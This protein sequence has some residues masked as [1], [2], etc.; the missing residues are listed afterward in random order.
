MA[1][2]GRWTTGSTEVLLWS[3][4]NLTL[5]VPVVIAWMVGIS[6]VSRAFAGVLAGCDTLSP[7][8]ST[9]LSAY[10]VALCVV[11]LAEFTAHVGVLVKAIA[12]HYDA[13]IFEHVRPTFLSMAATALTAVRLV[14]TV[15]GTL[16][17]ALVVRHCGDAIGLRVLIAVVV[18]CGW[19]AIAV[20]GICAMVLFQH[21]TQSRT[22]EEWKALAR[23]MLCHACWTGDRQRDIEE[24]GFETIAANLAELAADIP[25]ANFSDMILSMAMVRALQKRQPRRVFLQ[26]PTA[27]PPCL[28]KSPPSST[29]SS[30]P[31][32]RPYSPLLGDASA[33][34]PDLGAGDWDRLQGACHFSKYALGAYGAPL[35]AMMRPWAACCLPNCLLQ[36]RT[37]LHAVGCCACSIRAFLLRTGLSRADVIY[38]NLTSQAGTAVFYVAADH[39]R[40][41]LVVCVRG[42]HSLQDLLNDLIIDVR[43]LAPYGFPPGSHMHG[44]VLN[45]AINIITEIKES[46]AVRDFLDLHPT[47]GVVLTGHSLGAAIAGTMTLLSRHCQELNPWP[48]RLVHCYSF[49]PLKLYDLDLAA[50]DL[51]ASLITSIVFG[52]DLISRLSLRSV[53]RL[54]LQMRFI[55][56]AA[57]RFAGLSRHDVLRS[58]SEASDLFL[59]DIASNAEAF[60][61]IEDAVEE[62][63]DAHL[64]VPGRLFHMVEE[65]IARGNRRW[66][67]PWCGDRQAHRCHLWVYPCDRAAL[68]EIVIS[69]SMMLH[70]FPQ[71][72]HRALKQLVRQGN[73]APQQTCD[74]IEIDMGLTG[75]ESPV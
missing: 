40:R 38:A 39:P 58:H 61:R 49:A 17:A 60:A 3:I 4:C 51:T 33:R 13:S 44:G 18:A 29:S 30:P 15:A 22:I 5:Q 9:T 43:P 26:G 53:R 19:V 28:D 71:T 54:K 42:T 55:N 62:A 35:Y 73:G 12:M 37:N 74:S 36:D 25:F 21:R 32:A 59:R 52:H 14:L 10:L 45:A 2:P 34:P 1:S 8:V 47:Y 41:T 11:C 20:N 24:Q 6:I 72:Y 56:E 64:F 23:C 46:R 57:Q 31:P 75:N 50:S 67:W 7:W 68:E 65:D 69:K 16:F 63:S 70:H 66:G 27:P 48:S